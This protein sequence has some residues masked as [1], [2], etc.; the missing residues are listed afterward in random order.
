MYENIENHYKLNFSKF[1]KR[2]SYRAGG[3]HQAED[4]VQESYARAMKYYKPE[5]VEDFNK[6]FS[7]IMENSFNDLM[8]EASGLSYIEEGEEVLGE[9]DCRIMDIQTRREIRSLISSKGGNRE[10][11]LNLHIRDGF[12]PIDISKQTEHSYKYTYKVIS[13]FRKE[14]QELYA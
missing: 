2:F 11:I 14:L 6:W 7:V 12:S 13:M 5:R 4:I 1:V 10:E 9:E 3:I 8:R